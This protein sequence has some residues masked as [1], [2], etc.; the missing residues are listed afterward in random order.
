MA[1]T[2]TAMQSHT[3][4]TKTIRGVEIAQFSIDIR[5]E[6]EKLDDCRIGKAD[7][8]GDFRSHKPGWV[9]V[10][11]SQRPTQRL[12]TDKPE[13]K[14]SKGNQDKMDVVVGGYDYV[15]A[16]KLLSIPTPWGSIGGITLSTVEISISIKITPD[17]GVT[18]DVRVN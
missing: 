5:C 1:T 12:E 16:Y 18:K 13:C 17:G 3:H 15:V 14:S 7:F 2:Y 6:W 10:S 8:Y 4:K 9:I 11:K